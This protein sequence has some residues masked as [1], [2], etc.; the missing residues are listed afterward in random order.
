MKEQFYINHASHISKINDIMETLSIEVINQ[1][2]KSF[3]IA[4]VYQSPDSNRKQFK[5]T[6]KYEK[7]GFS[8]F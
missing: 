8:F 2:K 6:L 4:G 7:K 5:R 1:M 3:I